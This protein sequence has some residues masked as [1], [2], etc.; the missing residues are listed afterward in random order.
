MATFYEQ[1]LES[2]RRFPDNVALEIQRQD[3]VERVTFAEL[4][5]MS[6]SVGARTNE[7]CRQDFVFHSRRRSRTPSSG[8]PLRRGARLF[9]STPHFMPIR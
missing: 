3:R 8:W 7:N 4:T 2:A 9:R 5:R 6:E 1:F